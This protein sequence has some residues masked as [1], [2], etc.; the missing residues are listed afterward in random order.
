MS[1]KAD[2]ALTGDVRNQSAS[3]FAVANQEEWYH[4]GSACRLL[5]DDGLFVLA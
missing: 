3:G 2:K 4:V 5:R 1:G